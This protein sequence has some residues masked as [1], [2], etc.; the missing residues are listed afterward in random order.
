ML[1]LLAITLVA[2]G[3]ED[4]GADGRLRVV[5][6]TGQIHD[7][8]LNIAG[9]RVTATGLLGPGIDPHL[10]VATEGDVSTFAD[11]DIIF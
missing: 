10:Y 9:D 2:C 11:A 8:V 3:G 5:S 7:A 1:L 6:T 4:A